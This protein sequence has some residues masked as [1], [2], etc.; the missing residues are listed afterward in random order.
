MKLIDI[1]RQ[2]NKCVLRENAKLKSIYNK[3]IKE[4]DGENCDV[5]ED[6]DNDADIKERDDED[7]SNK[8][9]SESADTGDTTQKDEMMTA[10]E[11]FGE[12][13]DGKCDDGE[14]DDGKKVTEDEPLITPEEFFKEV[15]EDS[16]EAS[17][18]E[19]K[20]M[21]AKEFFGEV[22]E[23]DSEESETEAANEADELAEGDEENEITE[24]DDEGDDKDEIAKGDD[25]ELDESI[26]E[27][28]MA[29]RRLFNS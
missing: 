17:N 19:D 13:G 11:F 9:T 24:G 3:L 4:C 12:C 2:Y 8:D 16:N 15:S 21:T 10:K 22:A 25:K 5:N 29:N 20:V 7:S 27:Y 14:C 23:D 26:K 28:Q 1:M 6:G 18:P